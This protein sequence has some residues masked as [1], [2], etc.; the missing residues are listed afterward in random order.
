M[1][2]KCSTGEEDL[3]HSDSEAYS[4][5]SRAGTA[6]ASPPHPNVTNTKTRDPPH[7]LK[8]L[9]YEQL[10]FQRI[11]HQLNTCKVQYSHPEVTIMN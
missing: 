4:A 3:L 5:L 8:Y 1:R 2:D 11:S 7:G 10:S 6:L 9:S